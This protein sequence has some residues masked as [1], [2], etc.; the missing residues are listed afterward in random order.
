MVHTKGA[1]FCS[2]ALNSWD[3]KKTL[4]LQISKNISNNIP[5]NGP[6][7]TPRYL[8]ATYNLHPTGSVGVDDPG[9]PHRLG[10]LHI[11]WRSARE[12]G[13]GGDSSHDL[14]GMVRWKRRPEIK[15][16]F[17]D[18]PN[19]LGMKKRSRIVVCITWQVLKIF[20][21]EKGIGRLWLTIISF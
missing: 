17:D 10:F 6:L 19:F 5:L 20:R 16:C 18:Q 15:G 3:K 13:T 4:V 8:I 2:K 11:A 9:H 14:L 1:S 7:K 21:A 12:Q